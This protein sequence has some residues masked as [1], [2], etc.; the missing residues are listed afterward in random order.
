[1]AAPVL[2]PITDNLKAWGRELTTYLQRQLPRLYFKSAGDNPS[3]NGII[4][5]DEVNGYPVVSK[6]NEF[7][8]IVLEDGHANLIRTTD[9]AAAAINTA[10]AIQYD[11]PTGNVGISLDGTDPTKIVFAEAGEYLLM[12]SAQ[13]SSTSSS[14]VNFYFWPRLNGT[15]AAGS[16]M[17]NALHQNNATLVVSRAAKFDVTAGDYLQVMWAVDSTSGFLDARAATAFAPAAPA[18][19]L[20]ITR[21]HG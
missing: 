12:F 15:D 21:M 3:E 18:S 16:T 2:P 14:T 10:Y 1:M 9:V 7:V 6:G 13:I 19:T 5:W 11:T 8:Q 17:G 20:A 4:L